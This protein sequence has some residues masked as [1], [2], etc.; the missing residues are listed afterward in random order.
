MEKKYRQI[1]LVVAFGVLLFAAVMNLGSVMAFISKIG[2]LLL[3]V[4][5]GLMI[6]IVL[7]VPANGFEKLIRRIFKRAKHKPEGKVLHLISLLLTLLCV[8]A[9]LVTLSTMVIPQLVKTVESIAVLVEENLPGWLNFL[10]ENGINTEFIENLRS[11]FDLGKIANEL[12]NNLKVIFGSIASAASAT[13]ST[14]TSIAFGLIIAVYVMVDR[15]TLARQSK[16]LIDAYLK[17]KTAERTFYIAKLIKETYAKF[18]S[19]QC[20]EALIL[21]VMILISFL[22][23]KLPYAGLVAMATAVC[24]LVPYVGAFISGC[25][26]V[27]LALLVS[28]EKALLCFIVYN[29][30]QFVEN[31]F[32]YPHVVGGSVGLSPFWTLVAVLVG[33]KLFGL[34]G[35]ILF[36][37]LVAVIYELLCEST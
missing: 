11:Q 3:P 14:A 28:P 2:D 35:M 22:V 1:M 7:C 31:Q 29:V 12:G 34:V 26:G 30:V 16:K 17:P 20:V 10:E 19:G 36:I 5:I 4:V 9:I 6:A 37:P 27:I 23:F 18:F 13:L 21:G 24:A 25:L 32:I 15:D 8:A 33:G